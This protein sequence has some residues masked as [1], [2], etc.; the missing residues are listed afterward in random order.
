M[1]YLAQVQRDRIATCR[2]DR[3]FIIRQRYYI[4]NPIDRWAE[5]HTFIET[6]DMNDVVTEIFSI[7]GPKSVIY[8]DVAK[9]T[10]ADVGK[11]VARKVADRIRSGLYDLT[12]DARDFIEEYF[13][14]GS[15]IPAAT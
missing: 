8:V 11:E 14:P 3:F 4:G 2:H 9:G 13:M 7:D 12:D 10:S 1:D 15:L 6:D 5:E